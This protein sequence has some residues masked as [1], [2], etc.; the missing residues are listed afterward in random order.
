MLKIKNSKKKKA[1][2]IS[3]KMKI[4]VII[5]KQGKNIQ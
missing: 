4:K 1:I 2:L 3:D 5:T